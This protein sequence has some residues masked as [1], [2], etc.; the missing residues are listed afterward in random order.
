[1][2]S[3]RPPVTTRSGSWISRHTLILSLDVCSAHCFSRAAAVA[4]HTQPLGVSSCTGD[5]RTHAAGRGAR[6]RPPTRRVDTATT[7]RAEYTTC[8]NSGR[9]LSQQVSSD[10]DMICIQQP[11]QPGAHQHGVSH[12][13]R[14]RLRWH[15]HDEA[16]PAACSALPS[17][18]EARLPAE[19]QRRTDGRVVSQA[20][21]AA[22]D[23]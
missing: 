9:S 3:A 8:S 4:R 18:V 17:T 14:R 15:R 6:Y 21:T 13:Q 23:R 10:H 11:D 22:G 5:A 16:Q 2:S 7:L 19:G 20:A 1:M 12:N